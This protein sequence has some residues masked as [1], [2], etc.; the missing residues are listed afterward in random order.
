MSAACMQIRDRKAE[1][2]VLGERM[3]QSPSARRSA[4]DAIG[5]ERAPEGAYFAHEDLRILLRNELER[6]IEHQA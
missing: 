1:A 4:S 5:L 2:L 6:S 3:Y